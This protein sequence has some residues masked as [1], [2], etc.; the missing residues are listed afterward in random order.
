MTYATKAWGVTATDICLA[1][2]IG[3]PTEII[4]PNAAYSELVAALG[5]KAKK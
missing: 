5:E 2:S 3:S 4:D 1:L